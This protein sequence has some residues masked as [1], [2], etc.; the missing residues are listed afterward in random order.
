[1]PFWKGFKRNVIPHQTQK[2]NSV[3]TLRSGS[4]ALSVATELFMGAFSLILLAWT[5][6]KTG[7]PTSRGTLML[8]SVL[9]L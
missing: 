4:L 3:L 6:V 5:A 2:L 1:M 9:D 7:A 8:T